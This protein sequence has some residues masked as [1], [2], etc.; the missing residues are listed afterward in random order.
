MILNSTLNCGW[1]F[2]AWYMLSPSV[3]LH[4][5]PYIRLFVIRLMITWKQCHVCFKVYPNPVPITTWNGG[6]FELLP[7]CTRAYSFV[8]YGDCQPIHSWGRFHFLWWRGGYRLFTN[9]V[10]LETQEYPGSPWTYCVLSVLWTLI[11]FSG[12]LSRQNVC[13]EF[14]FVLFTIPGIKGRN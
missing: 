12:L 14:I 1:C 5:L 8:A 10:G 2:I 9:T 13:A 3:Y 6:T 7:L 11:Y 4:V